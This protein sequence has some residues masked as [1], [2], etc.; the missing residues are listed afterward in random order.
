MGID[1]FL[2]ISIPE[3][4]KIRMNDIEE[5]ERDLHFIARPLKDLVGNF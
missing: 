2:Y 4:E 3:L 1:K 5:V